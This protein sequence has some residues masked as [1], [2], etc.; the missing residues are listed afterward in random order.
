M[1]IQGR[2]L[3]H[4]DEDGQIYTTRQVINEFLVESHW[5]R[6][7]DWEMPEKDLFI[8]IWTNEYFEKWFFK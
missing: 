3:I 1:P 2:V 8:V 6:V 7:L 4:R 5:E